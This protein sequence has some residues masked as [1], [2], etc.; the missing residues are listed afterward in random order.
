MEFVALEK[1]ALYLLLE[2]A[3]TEVTLTFVDVTPFMHCA[4][5]IVNASLFTELLAVYVAASILFNVYIR[6]RRKMKERKM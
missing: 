2:T 3:T 1:N 5:D 6:E 4:T